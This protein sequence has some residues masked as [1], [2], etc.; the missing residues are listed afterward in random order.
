[1]GRRPPARRA[2][3]PRGRW[4]PSAPSRAAR[5]GRATACGAR[6]AAGSRPPE[7]R[8]R[9]RPVAGVGRRALRRTDEFPASVRSQPATT[10]T[11]S[12]AP[13]RC[14]PEETIVSARENAPLGSPCWVDLMTSDT[15]RARAFYGELLGWECEDANPEFGGYA[16]FRHDG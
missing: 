14:S 7:S 11:T 3:P 6:S 16:N 4:R 12:P 15:D 5:A 13:G 2:R 10:T 8:R 9:T 1:A